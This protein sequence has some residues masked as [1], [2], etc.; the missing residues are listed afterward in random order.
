MPGDLHLAYK[1]DT[2]KSSMGERFIEH[3]GNLEYWGGW[4]WFLCIICFIIFL[5]LCSLVINKIWKLYKYIKSPDKK[6]DD[7]KKD[8]FLTK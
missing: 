3:I 1:T 7:K 4:D 5:R 8:D 6:E 2:V